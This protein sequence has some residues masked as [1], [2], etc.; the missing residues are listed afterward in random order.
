M[1]EQN[2]W[3][4]V[5]KENEYKIIHRN[6][7]PNKRRKT[8][9]TCLHVEEPKQPNTRK[10]HTKAV[11][12]NVVTRT[13]PMI[14]TSN[15]PEQTQ[16][17]PQKT[18]LILMF[19]NH[20]TS[21]STAPN[22]YP[23]NWHWKE[24]GEIKRKEWNMIVQAP[25]GEGEWCRYINCLGKKEKYKKSDKN[26]SMWRYAKPS[27]PKRKKKYKTHPLGKP[28]QFGPLWFP[29]KGEILELRHCAVILSGRRSTHD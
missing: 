5:K 17:K 15:S 22:W 12:R 27:S 28:W 1:R 8:P 21:L 29:R 25:W 13:V 4:L 2:E 6:K 16:Q 10:L 7:A 24:R 9:R 19:V 26:E 18:R 23:S 14:K 20:N 11:R 3:Q